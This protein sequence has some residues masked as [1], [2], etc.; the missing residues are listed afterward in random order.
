MRPPLLP[1]P[2]SLTAIVL[3]SLAKNARKE[4]SSSLAKNARDASSQNTL[5]DVSVKERTQ[6]CVVNPL[7]LGFGLHLKHSFG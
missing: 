7:M 5:L 3:A 1:A 4:H 2:T 6:G